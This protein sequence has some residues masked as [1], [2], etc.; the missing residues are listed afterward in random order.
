MEALVTPADRAHEGDPDDPSELLRWMDDAACR[1]ADPDVFFPGT[2]E[3][4]DAAVQVCNRCPVQAACLDYAIA[5]GL[6]EGVF[7]GTTPKQRRSFVVGCENVG[8]DLAP[9]LPDVAS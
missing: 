4:P 9:Q 3:S 7:G 1:A 2:G 8:G 6:T 5:E